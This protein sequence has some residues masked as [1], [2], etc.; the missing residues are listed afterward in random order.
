MK[1]KEKKSLV[2][3]VEVIKSKKELYE[4]SK[5]WDKM[6]LINMTT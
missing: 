1:E 5:K 2:E 3:R 4:Y 6:Y